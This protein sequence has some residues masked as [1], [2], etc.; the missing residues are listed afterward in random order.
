M[1]TRA[2][3][4]PMVWL[5]AV[6][7]SAL[8]PAVWAGEQV[9]FRISDP[10]GDDYGSGSLVYPLRDDMRDG[11]LDLVSLVARAQKNG[12]EFEATFARF[13]QRPARRPV[14][15]VGT[16]LD[17]LAR[18]GFYTF[19]LDIY[20]DT[21]RAPNSGSTIT[22][23][24]RRATI[25]P[26]DAWEKAICLTPRPFD[27]R[28]QLKAMLEKDAK[29]ELRQSQGRVDSSDRKSIETGVA[30]DVAESVFFPTLVWVSGTK[31]NFFV[32]ESFLGGPASPRWGYV[33]AVS[34]AK[35]EEKVDLEPAL[36]VGKPDEPNLM[37]MQVVP[38]RSKEAFGGGQEDD[39]LQ[40]PLVDITVPPG[41][42][43]EGILK[44][45]DLR[46]GRFVELHA[47]VPAES[48]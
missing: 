3:R 37:V 26:Q 12:T 43:Q 44:D 21:D 25:A 32:P 16:T 29:K 18:F 46:T 40:P 38:G 7:A 41:M 1:M 36:G 33:V 30:R 34:G 15:S 9:I 8:V 24:G 13:V 31:I 6:S 10:R 4:V 35:I 42:T 23:P 17:T 11:D 27:A 22:L 48:K 28:T 20:I 19:N 45:Y 5:L 47:V 39:D 2:L 14:D